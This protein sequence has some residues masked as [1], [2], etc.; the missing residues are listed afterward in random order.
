MGEG[1]GTPE[2]VCCLLNGRVLVLKTLTPAGYWLLVAMCACVCAC[3]CVRVCVCVCVCVLCAGVG[4]DV[5][6]SYPHTVL[7][8]YTLPFCGQI[9]KVHP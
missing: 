3:V 1:Q 4:M 5:G 6:V 8:I 2:T 7:C 9:K